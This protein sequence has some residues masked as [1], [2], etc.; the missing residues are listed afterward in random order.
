[1]SRSSIDDSDLRSLMTRYQGADAAALDELVR[2]VS[3]LLLRYFIGSRMSREDADDL[4]Q[5]CWIKIHR[6]RHTYRPSE[7]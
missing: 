4:L 6:S 2:R 5:D 3:P 1:M 7:P